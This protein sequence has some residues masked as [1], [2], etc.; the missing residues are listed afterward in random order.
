MEEPPLPPGTGSAPLAPATG[1]CDGTNVERGQHPPPQKLRKPN[2][3]DPAAS[4]TT[5][6]TLPDLTDDSQ[7]TSR[8]HGSG[9]TLPAGLQDIIH[10]MLPADQERAHH[11]LQQMGP[12]T[13][14]SIP[15]QLP[16]CSLS[17][18]AALTAQIPKETLVAAA[19]ATAT[20]NQQVEESTTAADSATHAA[21]IASVGTD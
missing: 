7:A 17:E 8:G 11:L 13:G 16:F 12:A 3:Q 20:R 5:L 10:R 1:E 15:Y 14:D 2:P 19:A 4:T 21:A 18:A 6:G 9:A